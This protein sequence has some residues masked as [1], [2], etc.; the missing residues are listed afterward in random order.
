MFNKMLLKSH[1]PISN[2][3]LLPTG[4]LKHYRWSGFRTTNINRYQN[5]IR[6][7]FKKI[8]IELF[9]FL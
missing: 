3:M 9:V 7:A 2:M 4:H 8:I 6:F 1:Q 5:Y